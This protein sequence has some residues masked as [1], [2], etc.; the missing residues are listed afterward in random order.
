M[1]FAYPQSLRDENEQLA[2]TL[3]AKKATE[4]AQDRLTFIQLQKFA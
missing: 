2:D 3:G 4:N 1:R